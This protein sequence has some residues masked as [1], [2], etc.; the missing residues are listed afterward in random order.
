[1]IP[2]YSYRDGSTMVTFSEPSGSSHL[3][4]TITNPDGFVAECRLPE[5]EWLRLS[6][7]LDYQEHRRGPRPRSDGW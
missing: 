2:I 5:E 7:V 4:V 1:M 3:I 6:T